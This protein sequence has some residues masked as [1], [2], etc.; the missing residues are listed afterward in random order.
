[1]KLERL[2]L[3]HGLYAL[4]F[5]LALSVR[6]IN[7]NAAPLS[8]FEASW[9]LQ[10]LQVAR[11]EML[12]LDPQPAYSLLTGALFFL[13]ESSNALARFL[14]VLAGSGLVLLPVF[15]R[16]LLG[17]QAALI[18]A[19]GLAFDPGLVALSRL[20][21]GPAFALSFGLLALGWWYVGQPF[22]AA[23][24]G[25]VALLSGPSV[26]IGALG[27]ILALVVGRWLKN[28]GFLDW[29]EQRGFVTLNEAKGLP[30]NQEE[31]PRSAQHDMSDASPESK[32]SDH[33]QGTRR[34]VLWAGLATF[35]IVG[36]LF[37][38]YPQGLSAF[39]STLP[40]Y[41]RGWLP[42]TALTPSWTPALLLLVALIVYQP[43]ALVFGTL[44]AGRAWLL[45]NSL[46][47]WLSVWAGVALLLN[48]LYPA[49]Q[50]T[51]LCW[52][53]VPLWA[54]AA[55]EISRY[56]DFAIGDVLA[57]VGQAGLI[58]ILLILGWL[59]FTGL[60]I[61]SPDPEAARLR[62]LLIGGVLVLGVL[63]TM[64]VWLGW[65]AE[66]ALKGLAWGGLLGLGLFVLGAA[67]GVTRIRQNSMEGELWTPLPVAGQEAQLL[68]S[69][70]DLAEWRHGYRNVLDITAIVRGGAEAMPSLRWA[71]R[72][73]LSA[74]YVDVLDQSSSPSV[75]IAPE[76]QPEPSLALSYRGES[77]TWRGYPF[78]QE[79]LTQNWI[80]WVVFRRIPIRIE[81]LTLWARSDIFPGGVPSAESVPAGNPPLNLTP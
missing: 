80:P 32:V 9:A 8:D 49:R 41:L 78:W 67:F 66:V 64:L 6:L 26:L 25:A 7:L 65:S 68:E 54:L 33:T 61:P 27:L 55:Q 79:G 56:L 43:L 47:K 76:D 11:G 48:L 13:F 52:V 53:L 50:V 37:F 21:G 15:F 4:A 77:F 23:I 28:Y 57:I 40:V 1:M 29:L 62:W 60:T 30:T 3:E 31:M 73:F 38:R 46:G 16:R 34:Q 10:A 36:T 17:Q 81:R 72:D 75:V 45:R 14:P 63:A 19:F 70:G 44:A 69:L 22:W 42:S 2:S 5:A 18:F 24:F 51:D 20:A 59:N 12:I 39:V 58:F 35:I 74:Q 71:L